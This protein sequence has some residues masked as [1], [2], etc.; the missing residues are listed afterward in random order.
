MR[1]I[2]S[3][4]FVSLLALALLATIAPPLPAD[5]TPP[6]SPLTMP[7]ALRTAAEQHPRIRSASAH[8]DASRARI[9]QARAGFLP[10]IHAEESYRRTTSPLWSFGT[11]LNQEAITSADFD[12]GR[13]NDPDPIDNF[14]TTL[15]LEWS[16][17]DGGQTPIGLQQAQLGQQVA[18]LAA[19]R[20]RQEVIAQ[21]AIAFSGLALARQ[22]ATVAAQAMETA[23]SHLQM[24]AARLEAGLSVESDLLRARVRLAELERGLLQ[25][26][27]QARVAQAALCAAMGT[28]TGGQWELAGI[29]E[30][31]LVPEGS[32][33][34]WI[35]AALEKRPDL[36]QLRQQLQIARAEVQKSR[37]AHLPQ[38][39]LV[40]AYEI[41]S[42]DWGEQAENYTLGAAVRLNL[43]SG[44]RLAARTLENRALL[45][46][47]E[48]GLAEFVSGIE[49]QTRQAF[50]EAHSAWKSIQVAQSAAAQ[51]EEGLRIVQ[52][53]YR[54]GLLPIVALLDAEMALQGARLGFHAALHD[55]SV[56]RS[57]L[58]LAAGT[59]DVDFTVR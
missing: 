59:L 2:G 17:F 11:R 40:G 41:N 16:L 1:P 49:I 14:A 47:I 34:G 36:A 39:I 21:A 54:N 35:A 23:R 24:A 13:L 3:I 31:P 20:T 44:G 37:A 27:S 7:Q 46:R 33:E 52:H 28:S 42:E 56:A 51:A 12:P 38:V 19:A 25:A 48:A 8:I 18:T 6:L 26:E 30:A 45:A 57:R 15:S 53:R 55:Y 32:L 4:L 58:A 43:H 5:E 9:T 50:S 10:Q 29:P 22:N